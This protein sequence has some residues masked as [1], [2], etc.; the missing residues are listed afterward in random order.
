MNT[1]GT[2]LTMEQQ[3]V[4]FDSHQW[5]SPINLHLQAKKLLIRAVLTRAGMI[6]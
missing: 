4:H 5:Y 1:H 3:L 6:F 2:P